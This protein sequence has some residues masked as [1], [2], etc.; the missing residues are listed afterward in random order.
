MVINIHPSRINTT[1]GG[2]AKTG[3]RRPQADTAEVI[4]PV[5]ANVNFI[6]SPESLRTLIAGAV[7]ALRKGI[8]WERGTILNLMV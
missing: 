3:T 2:T 6:P 7:A 4:V 8:T 1:P 5:R